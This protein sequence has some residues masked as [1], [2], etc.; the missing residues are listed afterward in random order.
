MR[1]DISVI[2]ASYG[3]KETILKTVKSIYSQKTKHEYEVIIIDS[4]PENLYRFVKKN[5]PKIRG[6]WLPRQTGQSPART[7]GAE[8]A[9]ADKLVYCDTDTILEKDVLEKSYN[10]LNEHEVVSFGAENA[11]P[12]SLVGQAIFLTEFTGFLCEY[13]ARNTTDYM[14]FGVAF[15]KKILGKYGYFIDQENSQD[16]IHGWLLTKKGVQIF[17][18]SGIKVYH[19]N[20]TKFKDAFKVQY[21][22]GRTSCRTRKRMLLPKNTIMKYPFLIPLLPFYRS[23]SIAA[24]LL[25]YA[26]KKLL[27]FILVYPLAF[28]LLVGYTA[29]FFYERFFGEKQERLFAE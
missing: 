1:P 11:N 16:L 4:S 26:R 29:G 5:Y 7:M 13:P 14:G 6:K 8:M 10:A 27:I 18:D 28:A 24:K 9:K 21:G 22:I 25:R 19:I 20:R 12:E 17:F 3:Q 15:N 23:I 2:L